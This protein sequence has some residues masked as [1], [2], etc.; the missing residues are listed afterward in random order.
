M[1]GIA[2]AVLAA[3]LLHQGDVIVAP[4]HVGELGEQRVDGQGL[5]GSSG[6]AGKVKGACAC[7][8]GD[9]LA[10]GLDMLGADV[11]GLVEGGAGERVVG[12][13]VDLA[14]H[15]LGGLEQRLDGRRLEQRQLAAGQ[16][17]AMG[18]VLG[19][20]LAGQSGSSD[21]APRCAGR[22]THA[23]PCS[24]AGAAP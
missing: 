24:G 11:A 23:P 16:A 1:G 15:P 4:D 21:G 20:L 6:R 12:Q 22:A 19:Q 9:L 18:E 7:S 14:R 10:G 5:L 13:A 2:V 3:E 8:W 17:Q